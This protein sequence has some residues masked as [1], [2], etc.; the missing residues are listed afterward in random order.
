[1]KRAIVMAISVILAL[2]VVAPAAFGQ[3]SRASKDPGALGAA[4][5]SWLVST[6][7]AKNPS[8]GDYT[9]GPKC[10]GQ[11]VTKTAN[12]EWFLAG[13]PGELSEDGGTVIAGSGA[14]RTCKVPANT[15]I[16]FP[17]VNNFCATPV[18]GDTPEKL[19]ACAKN[20]TDDFLADGE[21]Y[22]KVDGQDIPSSRIVR[23][24]SQPFTMDFYT[25]KD[26]STTA[27]DNIFAE[28]GYVGEQTAASDGLWVKLPPLKKGEKHTIVWGGMF[29]Y[30]GGP[31]YDGGPVYPYFKFAQDTTYHITAE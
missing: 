9:G 28:F 10:D 7:V 31:I 13:S 16:F 8:I 12:R 21:Y 20:I 5:W 11:P 18:D 14:E 29:D 6:P 1:V 26:D 27:D 2:I 22:A 19:F 30:E 17:I 25:G 15:E 4:W 23:G 24:T 3:S